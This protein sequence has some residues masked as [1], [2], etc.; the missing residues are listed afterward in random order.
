MEQRL[1]H[2]YVHLVKVDHRKGVPVESSNS[3]VDDLETRLSWMGRDFEQHFD[4]LAY[5][6]SEILDRDESAVVWLEAGVHRAV[7]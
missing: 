2:F 3:V 4:A 1:W 6:P 7:P 5:L